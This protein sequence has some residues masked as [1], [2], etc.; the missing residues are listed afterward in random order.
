MLTVMAM[1]ILAI[2]QLQLHLVSLVGYVSN[3]TDCDD[4]NSGIHTGC[5]SRARLNVDALLCQRYLSEHH[6]C[7]G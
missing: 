2:Q 1:V 5:F 6:I 3:N 4:N 7:D